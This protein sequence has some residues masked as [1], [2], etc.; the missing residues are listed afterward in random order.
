MAAGIGLVLASQFV[1]AGQLL[2]DRLIS[3]GRMQLSPL[4]VVGCEGLLGAMLMVRVGHNWL[5]LCQHLW[6]CL[7]SIHICIVYG[8]ERLTL[9]GEGTSCLQMAATCVLLA[10]DQLPFLPLLGSPPCCVWPLPGQLWPAGPGCT[11]HCWCCPCW[12]GGLGSCRGHLG[13][14]SND[15]RHTHAAAPVAGLHGLTAGL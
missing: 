14:L 10:A 8:C 15:Y 4:K 5:A 2:Y 3:N 7:A 9:Q 6:L 12:L 1:A 13:Q 11:A